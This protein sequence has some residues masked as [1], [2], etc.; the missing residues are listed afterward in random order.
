M[1]QLS[2]S[3]QIV[4]V[5]PWPQRIL[6]FTLIT[7]LDLGFNAAAGA[8]AV[9]AGAQKNGLVE[10]SWVL[11]DIIALGALAGTMKSGILALPAAGRKFGGLSWA[12][13]LILFILFN[14]FGICTL[15]VA[16]ICQRVLDGEVPKELLIAGLVTALPLSAEMVYPEAVTLSRIG[17]VT[18]IGWDALAGYTFA[19]M[20]ENQGFVVCGW[21]DAAAAGAVYG[22][23]SAAKGFLVI[24][25]STTSFE[26]QTGP[27]GARGEIRGLIEF[28][29][30]GK[31]Q[32]PCFLAAMTLEFW[33]KY[34]DGRS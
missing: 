34:G 19:R 33:E 16:S 5:T 8:A 25:L 30:D 31:G 4:E 14:P 26:A 3:T 13:S 27:G 10:N 21:A 28:W 18:L 11:P 15:I 23:L 12:M 20:A 9:A 7:I 1:D 24:L 29:V 17:T 6:I 32:V 2:A 22:A